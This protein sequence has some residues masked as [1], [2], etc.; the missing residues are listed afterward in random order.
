MGKLRVIKTSPLAMIQDLGRFG[1]RKYGIPQSGAMDVSAMK[2]AN[3]GVGNPHDSPVIEF[4]LMGMKL[5]ALEETNIAVVGAQVKVNGQLLSQN[6]ILLSIGDELE[7]LPPFNMYTYFAIGGKLKANNDFKSYSTY[8]M[9]G[10]GGYEGRSLKVSDI[11]ETVED[12]SLHQLEIAPYKNEDL[13]S[14]RFIEAPESHSLLES[15]EG[16]YFKIDPSSNRMGVRLI[17]NIKSDLDEIISSAVIPGTIQ[18]PPSGQP[19]VLMNDC[20][21][22]GGYPRIGKVI[23]DDLGKLAQIRPGKSIQF[24]RSF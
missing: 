13:T 23:D 19:I 17:G 7:I 9:A 22:T 1:F 11:L 15:L 12:G 4:A 24:K 10:F 6:S 14:I 3:S 16:K 18:L 5:Q 20:Q 21:T 2:S 8:L